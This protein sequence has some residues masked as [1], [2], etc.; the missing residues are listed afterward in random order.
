MQASYKPRG[1]QGNGEGQ[2]E[3]EQ[4]HRALT[5]AAAPRRAGAL[6][7]A[8]LLPGFSRKGIA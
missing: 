3:R 6:P 2:P 4:R 5:S 7:G 8:L 1:L